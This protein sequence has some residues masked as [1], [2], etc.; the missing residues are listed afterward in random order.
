MLTDLFWS[1]QDQPNGAIA[2]MH[3]NSAFHYIS[4]FEDT[5]KLQ[6]LSLRPEKSLSKR[7]MSISH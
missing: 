4:M 5:V 3:P 7:K 2:D 6:W 1:Q